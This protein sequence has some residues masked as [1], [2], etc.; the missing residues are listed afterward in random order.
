V[1]VLSIQLV[2]DALWQEHQAGPQ[3]CRFPVAGGL[4]DPSLTQVLPARHQLGA[5]P[6]VEG[7]ERAAEYE[8]VH[9]A[10]SGAF[11]R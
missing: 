3:D 4:R 1:S 11:E 10:R 9:A 6:L 7:A 8:H 2:S 5:D